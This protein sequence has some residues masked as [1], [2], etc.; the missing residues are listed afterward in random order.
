MDKDFFHKKP[1][2][3]LVLGRNIKDLLPLLDLFEVELVEQNPDLVISHG[4]DG[5]L[6][7]AERDFP[8]VPKCPIRDRKQNPKCPLHSE[9]STLEK[10]FSG[11]LQK[12]ELAKLV[13]TS[14]NGGELRGIN[15]LVL[16][17]ELVSSAIRYR[18]WVD[19]ELFRSQVVSDSLVI[20]TP[21]G[22]TGYFQSIT[23]GNIRAGIGLA[24]NNTMDGIGFSVLPGIARLE[25][26]VLRGPAVLMADNDPRMLKFTAGETLQ[27]RLS[28]KTT[29][30]YGV[31]VFR[32]QCCYQL[33]RDGV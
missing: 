9:L 33:R 13:A 3:V 20:S 29:V 31:D 28:A 15:D 30:V 21:F 22:S 14:S 32:C 23:R 7:G 27:V 1:L 18:L 25:V 17:R 26:Q 16:S 2:R 24:F 6:L 12:A 10:L 11:Q 19:G 5:S 8:G 4:G